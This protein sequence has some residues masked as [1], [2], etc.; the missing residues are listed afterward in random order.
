MFSVVDFKA[1]K[2]FVVF[3]IK[4]WFSWDLGDV[5]DWTKDLLSGAS[6]ND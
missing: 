3:E 1:A 6:V 5:E 4:S 2:L